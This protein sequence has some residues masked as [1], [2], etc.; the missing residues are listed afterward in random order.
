MTVQ[1]ITHLAKLHHL[2]HWQSQFFFIF[3]HCH[4]PVV[5]K[6]PCVCPKTNQISLHIRL[7]VYFFSSFEYC[8]SRHHHSRA[9]PQR[10]CSPF[11]PG[12]KLLNHNNPDS[13]KCL[14]NARVCDCPELA[15]RSPSL[16]L[17]FPFARLRVARVLIPSWQGK[18]LSELDHVCINL[19]GAC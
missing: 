5:T 15:G 2:T 1:V 12:E 7:N 4:V 9:V 3:L 11:S 17:F 14:L 10:V 13:G 8:H 6:L 18:R 16:G 19:E